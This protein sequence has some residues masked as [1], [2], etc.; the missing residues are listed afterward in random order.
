ML[1]HHTPLI[2]N[3]SQYSTLYLYIDKLFQY[4]LFSNKKTPTLLSGEKGLELLL[5]KKVERRHIGLI[6][7]DKEML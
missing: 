7:N 2:F 4:F 5:T 1:Y 3:S 6:M